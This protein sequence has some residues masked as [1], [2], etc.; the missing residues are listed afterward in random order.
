VLSVSSKVIFPELPDASMDTRKP[1]AF[2]LCSPD[3]YN[4]NNFQN[5]RR[6]P[7]PRQ[8]RKRLFL[9]ALTLNSL[10]TKKM[11]AMTI[12]HRAH[13]EPAPRSVYSPEGV[14]RK[15]NETVGL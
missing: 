5:H 6:P 13:F 11:G 12:R 3:K 1:I 9:L 2:P 15:P 4:S 14:Q 7:P 8:R 10:R